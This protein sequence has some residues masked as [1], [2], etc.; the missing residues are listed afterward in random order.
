MK[1]PRLRYAESLPR[2]AYRYL[3]IH[4]AIQSVIVAAVAGALVLWL[5][6]EPWK[7]WLL[8]ALPI[9]VVLSLVIEMPFINRLVVKNTSYEVSPTEVCIRKGV[10]LTRDTVISAAQILNVSVVEGPLLRNLGLAKVQFTSIS[11]VE[12]LGPVTLDDAHAIRNALL[13]AY[14][15]ASTEDAPA[16]VAEESSTVDA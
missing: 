10:L 3:N 4:D 13:G 16:E 5:V 14:A 1:P 8:I 2:N 15:G 9:L 11:H 6:P 7:T 12:P